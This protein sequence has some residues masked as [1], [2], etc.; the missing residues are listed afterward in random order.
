MKREQNILTK[1]KERKTM[2]ANEIRKNILSF[3]RKN[4][5]QKV[6][7]VYYMFDDN[8]WQKFPI[9]Y[10]DTNKFSYLAK[11]Y[12]EEEVDNIQKQIQEYIDE[13]NLTNRVH[14]ERSYCAPRN[15]LCYAIKVKIAKDY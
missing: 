15:S 11:L 1:K 14:L 13:N 7:P 3:V 5:A 9:Y 12:T 10:S 4:T 6:A 8:K 2:N